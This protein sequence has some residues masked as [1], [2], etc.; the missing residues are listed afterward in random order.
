MKTVV[1]LGEILLRLSPPQYQTL[2]QATT[3]ECQFGGSELNV[4]STLAQLGHKV[5]LVSAIPANDLGRMTKTFL[6]SRQISQDY[7]IEKG[8][9][10]GL[11]YYQKG[12]SLR[13]S[14][15]TYDRT[16]S[17]FWES[18]LADYD[19]EGVF[20]GADW[21][22]VSGITPALTDQLYQLTHYLMTKAK[23]EGLTVSFDLNFRA[24]LWDSFQEARELLSPLVALAD[25]CIG[26]EP[27]TLTGDGEKDLKDQLGLCRP[28]EDQALLETILA[29]L[30]KTYGVRSFAFTQREMGH[31]NEYLLKGYLYQDGQLYQTDKSGIQVLDRVGTGD[32]FTAGLIH[33][34]LQKESPEKSLAIAMASFKFKH[35]I[36][37][38]SNV[39]T[40]ADIDHLL[41]DMSHEIKR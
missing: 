12:F 33:G 14:R 36:E 5:S 22:H 9:R 7:I 20:E 28:Y 38:D 30:A 2:T 37:G 31:T 41:D 19:L 17:A 13:A 10:L 32:A 4:L 39:I 25:V 6:F 8:Q 15:V 18:R 11:Y 3:L 35:T 26:I 24:S 29:K 40:Q 1:S 16:Y 34:M 27:L 21:F 23:K